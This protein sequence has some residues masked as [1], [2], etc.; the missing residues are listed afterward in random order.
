MEA[1]ELPWLLAGG[2]IALH[3]SGKLIHVFY[4]VA[5]GI[6]HH[7]VSGPVVEGIITDGW[8]LVPGELL[9][10]RRELLVFEGEIPWPGARSVFWHAE[11]IKSAKGVGVFGESLDVCIVISN[12]RVKRDGGEDRSARRF[13]RDID[14]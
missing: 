11:P 14:I 9:K 7:K 1:R 13:A 10:G 8:I 2:Q 12:D 3:P 4:R 5:V 6:E